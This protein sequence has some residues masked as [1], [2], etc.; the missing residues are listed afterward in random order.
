M[1]HAEIV[2]LMRPFRQPEDVLMICKSIARRR[3]LWNRPSNDFTRFFQVF[4]KWV[5]SS[6]SCLFTV[7]AG[8]KAEMRAKDLAAEVASL[9]KDSSHP[10][11]WYLSE[12]SDQYRQGCLDL[13]DVLKTLIYQLLRQDTELSRMEPDM[14]NITKFQSTHS[15][16][17]WV[18]LLLLLLG[19]VQTCYMVIETEALYDLA[20]RDKA[21]S[22]QLHEIF[23]QVI[24]S[25]KSGQRT[26]K[27][28][29][30]TYADSTAPHQT[31]ISAP[32]MDG[33]VFTTQVSPARTMPSVNKKRMMGQ[34]GRNRYGLARQL[35]KVKLV[36]GI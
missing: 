21:W 4:N 13:S 34:T 16:A 29:L 36:N 26:M 6:D 33:S 18:N 24:D 3:C 8:P 9:L 7:R 5:A 28:L 15:D 25:A 22:Q 14:L 27:V 23:N 32:E 11:L 19:R 10:I 1:E 12:R 17:E 2:N 20:G 35:G 30:V 31:S